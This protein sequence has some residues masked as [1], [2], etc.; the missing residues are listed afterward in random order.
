MEFALA[1]LFGIIGG[2]ISGILPGIGATIA[3]V[4][5]MPV[6]L[7][8]DPIYILVSFVS[9]YSISQ[10]V[11]SVPAIILGIP[12]E[13]SSMAAVTESV[14][15]SRQHKQTEAIAGAAMGSLVGGLLCLILIVIG[16]D[17]LSYLSVAFKTPLR[18]AVLTALIAVIIVVSDNKILI[19]VALVLVGAVLGMIGI[20]GTYDREFL[21]FGNSDLTSGLP[22]FPVLL[23]LF[24]FPV[25]YRIINSHQTNS[26][27]TT[28]IAVS[29]QQIKDFSGSIKSSLRGTVLG[30][31]GGFC[32]GITC[33]FSSQI[34]YLTEGSINK[35][36]QNAVQRV[37]AA[38]SANNAGALSAMLPLIVMGIPISSSEAMILTILQMKSFTLGLQDFQSILLLCAL[39]LFIANLV[40]VI[41]AWPAARYIVK[42]LS[43]NTRVLYPVLFLVLVI[44]CWYIGFLN[45]LPVFYLSVVAGLIPVGWFL[46]KLD[47][48]PLI[49]SFLLVNLTID[50]FTTL[51]EIWQ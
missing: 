8:M 45:Y 51:I 27:P 48:M 22:L 39:A 47:T 50:S 43:I 49:V 18:V 6:L 7:M 36:P 3:I 21:T 41:I 1:V 23:S 13:S 4:L 40:G 2:I 31:F 33:T 15:I 32:P 44:F 34:A 38:E 9:L 16:I 10:Y 19:N 5:M 46:R 28:S 30:F 35:G 17:L 11:G 20:H 26:I 14:E 42:L 24:V 25:F 29:W 37:I 12:G